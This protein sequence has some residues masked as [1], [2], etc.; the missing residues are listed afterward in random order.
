MLP[1]AGQT[2][3]PNGLKFVADTQ[4][5]SILSNENQNSFFLV[6]NKNFFIFSNGQHRGLQ[7]VDYKR[8]F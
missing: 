6:L 4:P 5:G 3:G 1:I 8:E 2:A 7:L